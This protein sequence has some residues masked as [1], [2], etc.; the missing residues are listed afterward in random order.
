MDNSR[1]DIRQG[2]VN[3]NFRVG[4]SHNVVWTIS[5][6]TGLEKAVKSMFLQTMYS[7]PARNC[8][9]RQNRPH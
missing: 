8:T 7:D 5:L 3:C 4:Q 1:R 9:D 2:I 6:S